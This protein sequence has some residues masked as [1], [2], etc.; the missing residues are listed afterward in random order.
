MDELRPAN[1]DDGKL[2]C[3]MKQISRDGEISQYERDE[4]GSVRSQVMLDLEELTGKN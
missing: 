2:R 4:L 3:L 1:T